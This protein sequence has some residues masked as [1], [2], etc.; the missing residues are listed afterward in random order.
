MLLREDFERLSKRRYLRKPLLGVGE[1]PASDTQSSSEEGSAS[2][3]HIVS[4][5]PA[6]DLANLISV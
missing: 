1:G 3:S 4:E 6:D 2:D 5:D